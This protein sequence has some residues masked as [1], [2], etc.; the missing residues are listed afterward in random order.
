MQALQ[1]YLTSI[2]GELQSYAITDV[3]TPDRAAVLLKDAFIESFPARDRA[4]VR[5]FTETQMF[6][7]YCDT[8]IK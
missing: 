5:Q 2:C 1:D 8:V 4:F 7:V 6:S 3:Q